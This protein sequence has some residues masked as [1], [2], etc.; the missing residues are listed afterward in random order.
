MMNQFIIMTRFKH[1]PYTFILLHHRMVYRASIQ[2]LGFIG[3]AHLV[4]EINGKLEFLFLPAVD[5]KCYISYMHLKIHDIS[6]TMIEVRLRLFLDLK[7]SF[8]SHGGALFCW[9]DL[10]KSYIDNLAS[11]HCSSVM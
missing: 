6:S 8:L 5:I 9:N 2:F 1:M 7:L 3:S 4:R 10:I 11:I